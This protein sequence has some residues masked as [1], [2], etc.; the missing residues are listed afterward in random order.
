MDVRYLSAVRR[1]AATLRHPVPEDYKIDIEGRKATMWIQ[2]IKVR[3]A[4]LD[5]MRLEAIAWIEKLD[6]VRKAT[7]R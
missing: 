5:N 7:G 1:L 3:E 6:A 2:W 4:D